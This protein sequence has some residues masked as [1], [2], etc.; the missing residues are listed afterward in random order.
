MLWNS[1]SY[2]AESDQRHHSP[3]TSRMKSI[4]LTISMLLSSIFLFAYFIYSSVLSKRIRD[5][6]LA[7]TDVTLTQQ[8]ANT[9]YYGDIF[10]TIIAAYF[11]LF[12][13]YLA[14]DE[15]SSRGYVR[16]IEAVPV[17]TTVV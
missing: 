8:Q 7:G 3:S 4:A 12:S 2:F 13:L 15:A 11:V 14:Y 16:R 1:A 17:T 6:V 9:K 5:A 10:S